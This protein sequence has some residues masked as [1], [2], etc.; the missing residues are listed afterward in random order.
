MTRKALK[1]NDIPLE[2]NISREEVRKA[3]W[4]PEQSNIERGWRDEEGLQRIL[5]KSIQWGRKRTKRECYSRSQVKELFNG[6]NSSWYFYPDRPLN[7]TTWRSQISFYI[8]IFQGKQNP[9]TV[10]IEKKMRGGGE[11]WKTASME[12]SAENVNREVGW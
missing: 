6:I 2:M 5:N 1:L 11:K 7:F 10:S 4:S 9:S 12:N 3:E 8:S